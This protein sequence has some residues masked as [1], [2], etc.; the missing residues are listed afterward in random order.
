MRFLHESEVQSLLSKYSIRPSRDRGQ[1]FLI[2]QRIAQEIVDAADL[3]G[4]DTVL[5]IGGGLGILSQ[6]LAIS[7]NHLYVV[8]IEEGLV[9]ALSDRLSDYPNVTLIHG[10]AL[11]IDLP[12]V[13]KVVANLPYSVA[14]EITFRLLR[15]S[16]FNLAIL[17]YQKE[18]A[19][20]L[21]ATPD[22]SDYSRLSIDFQYLG[23]AKHL[24]DV[25]SSQFYPRPQVDSSILAIQKRKEGAFAQDAAIF[26]WMVHGMYSY[27][28]KQLKKAL[29]FWFKVLKQQDK[30]ENLLGRI[31]ERLDV[32]SRLR[33][34]KMSELVFL[35]DTLSEMIQEGD[36]PDPRGGYH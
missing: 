32:T 7:A 29:G 27:P 15:E 16:S 25:K 5:E 24:M 19:Q 34:L 26:F 18:F 13:T 31:H 14:S 1:S 10:D 21:L 3:S 22:S 11:S 12:V 9:Q 2:S 8:E 17:M 36:L 35:A 6:L 30:I 20:R 23:T 33:A 4:Q 28:N